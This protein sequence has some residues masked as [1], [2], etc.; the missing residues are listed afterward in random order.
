MS[1][2]G[3]KYTDSAIRSLAQKLA[4]YSSTL[5][6]REKQILVSI[7]LEHL[8][9]LD[10]MKLRDVNRLLTHDELQILN[11]LLTEPNRREM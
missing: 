4:L 3:S 2:H 6:V 10:R 7:L 1:F 9:P 11:D 8:D 5:C